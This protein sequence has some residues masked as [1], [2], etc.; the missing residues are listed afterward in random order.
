[1]C[2]VTSMSVSLRGALGSSV[3]ASVIG[4]AGVV[5]CITKSGEVLY[6]VTKNKLNY[7]HENYLRKFT[8]ANSR[9]T[10]LIWLGLI[11]IQILGVI[12]LPS[13]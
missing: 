10:S 6:R 7:D 11:T 2:D 8:F 5:L 1:M 3:V 12:L 9:E 4:G 13:P